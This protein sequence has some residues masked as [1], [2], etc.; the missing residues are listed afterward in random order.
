MLRAKAHH[1]HPVVSI[2]VHCLTRTV[3]H[4]IDVNLR[5]RELVKVRVFGDDRDARERLLA[6]VC[7]ELDA[8]PVQHLGKTLTLW[9]P[10]PAPEPVAAAVKTRSA[11]AFVAR[12][13]ERAAERGS[14]RRC[15]GQ[16]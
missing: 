10:A 4:E 3:L 5:A 6:Q 7:T 14:R 11:A 16:A 9:R 8:A 15:A 2:G 1:L 13:A 12:R